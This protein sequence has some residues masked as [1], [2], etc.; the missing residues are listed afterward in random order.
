MID[1]LCKQAAGK[2]AAVACFYFDFAAQEEQSPAEILGSVLNQVVDGLDEIPEKVVKAFRD[3]EKV[4]GGQRL[5]LSDIVEFL[6]YI[7]ASRRTFIGIDALDERPAR[8]R[9]ELLD[10]L[11]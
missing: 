5:T 2:N 7:F 3:R 6:Q 10:S 4:I 1:A 9:M 8:H 11:D